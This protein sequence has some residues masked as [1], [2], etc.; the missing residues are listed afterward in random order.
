MFPECS[1]NV[2]LL[3]QA[4]DLTIPLAGSAINGAEV[5]TVLY[6]VPYTTYCT[7]SGR[8][9]YLYLYRLQP[10][11]SLLYCVYIRVYWCTHIRHTGYLYNVALT[12]LALTPAVLVG[13]IFCAELAADDLPG[14]GPAH[15][16]RGRRECVR[17]HKGSYVKTCA[18][19]VNTSRT[20]K[21][22]AHSP[23]WPNGL[24]IITIISTTKE[25][26]AN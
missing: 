14:R 4:P 26:S 23:S 17:A 21:E 22:G 18:I 16:S 19:D 9:W 25:V 13:F 3:K 8:D 24:I 10:L 15:R 7:K 2:P 20:P 1:L 5:G 6:P 11:P 12:T